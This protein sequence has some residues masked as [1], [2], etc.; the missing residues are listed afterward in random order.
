MM[1]DPDRRKMLYCIIKDCCS[2]TAVVIQSVSK[3]V[4]SQ[5]FIYHHAKHLCEGADVDLNTF[6]TSAKHESRWPVSRPGRF[7]YR[8]KAPPYLHCGSH[9]LSRSCGENNTLYH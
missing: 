9:S 4:S 6:V 1:A 3:V 2:R 7:T 5:C 8:V